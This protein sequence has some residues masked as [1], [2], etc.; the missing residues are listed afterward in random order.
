[1]SAT[2]ASSGS[3]GVRPRIYLIDGMSNVFRAYYAIRGLSSSKGE[4]TNAV[5]GFL[6]MLRKLLKDEQPQ[7]LGIAFDVSTDTHRK[8]KFEAY[9]ANRRPMPDD[10]RP[11]LPFI[12][13]VVEAFRI[14]LLELPK[15]EADDVLGTLSKRAAEQGF[16]VVL[17]SP[18][19]DLMQLVGEHVLQY[20]T[21]RDRL[22]DVAGV[23][24]DFG[25]PPEKVV[26]VLALMGDTSDNVPGV[27]G[28]GEKGARQLIAEYGSLDA[29]LERAGEV[30][31]KAYREGLQQH[32]DQALLSREL[33]TI[34]CDLPIELELDRLRME[35]PDWDKL[36]ALCWQLDFNVVARELEAGRPKKPATLPAAF[37]LAS[38]E[39]WREKTAGLSGEIAVGLVGDSRTGELRPVGL[40]LGKPPADPDGDLEILFADF[41]REGLRE[42]VLESL[43]GYFADDKVTLVGHDL[44]E[45]VRLLGLRAEIAC[46]LFDTMLASYLLRSE[47]RSHDFGAVAIDRLHTTAMTSADAGFGSKGDPFPGDQALLRHASEQ[48]ALP[49]QML[50]VMRRE[51]AEASLSHLCHQIEVPLLAVLATLEERGVL[52]D[53]DYLA[54]MS[55]ELELE[56]KAIEQEIYKLAGGELNINSP[57]QLGF[58]LFEKMQLPSSGKTR[59]TKQYSTDAETLEELAGMGYELPRKILR[60][61]ELTKLKSTYVDALP[62]M[63]DS[64]G[65]IHT[66]FN[67]AVAATGRLSSA[68]PNLQN[69]PI[70]TEL[71]QRIRKAFRAA[72]GNLLVVADYSQIELRVLAHMA[73]EKVMIDAFRR[74]EDIHTSTAA[75]VFGIAPLLVSPDQRRYA[76]VINFGILYG[77]SPFGLS[78]ALGIGRKEAEVFIEKYLAQYPAIRRFTEETLAGAEAEGQVKTLFGRIRR[79]PDIKSR[80]YNLREGA[81]RMAVNAPIQGTAADLL[82]LAMLAVEKYLRQEMP[83]AHLLLTVHDELVLE[84]PAEVAEEVG[85]RVRQEMM[86]VADLAVPL[87]VEV[88]VGPT[89]YDA[90]G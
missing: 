6:Q 50:Q 28:I 8:D 19:K 3:S 29:L 58:V 60:F 32:R 14:P 51:L 36:L 69:I 66:R 21:G 42:A 49:W 1:M 75:A 45:V 30:S 37:D 59:K 13:Q 84:A 33:V 54:K 23:T 80:N 15:Y 17:V 46:S 9:K 48:V 47:L 62:Q 61:R 63:V 81:K 87:E 70:R 24:E 11:Q 71:G 52:L 83:A 55:G 39:E 65:R 67:Q 86:Q 43:R 27:P 18:D 82:K 34:H 73:D 56:V 78:Q 38:A 4:P 10:L 79:I 76:K 44:K 12:R 68:H 20:H 25:V 2:T 74:G 72:P 7:Y 85:R 57:Q 22:Y 35:E 88:G 26:D 77:M 53:L 64:E 89:W 41:R 16:E 5:F 90:K 40:V 31:R